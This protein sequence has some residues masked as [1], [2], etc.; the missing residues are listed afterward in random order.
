MKTS[1]LALTFTLAVLLGALAPAGVRATTLTVGSLD[2]D[3]STSTLRYLLNSANDG[4]VIQVPAGTIVLVAPAAI[5]SDGGNPDLDIQKNVTIQGAGAGQTVIDCGALPIMGFDVDPNNDGVHGVLEGITVQNCLFGIFLEGS[6]SLDLLDSSVV[7]NSGA[8]IFSTGTSNNLVIDG[9]DISHNIGSTG[10]GL[11]MTGANANVIITNST[12]SH[13]ES[14]SI[15]GGITMFSGSLSVFDSHI[16]DNVAAGPG[17]GIGNAGSVSVVLG[18]TEVSRNISQSTGGG[19]IFSAFTLDVENCDISDN[20]ALSDGD[21]GAIQS[22]FG[23]HVAGSLISGNRAEGLGGAIFSSLG[24]DLEDSTVSDNISDVDGDAAPT[25][26]G[27]GLFLA[28]ISHSIR[29]SVISGNTANTGLGGGIA[30]SAPSLLIFGS[31]LINNTAVQGDG[32]ALVNL[33]AIAVPIGNTTIAGNRAK[34]TSLLFPGKDSAGGGIVNMPGLNMNLVN[35]TLSGNEADGD[36]GGIANQGNVA[37]TNATVAGNV[38]DANAAGLSGGDGGGLWNNPAVPTSSFALRNSIVAGNQDDSAGHEAPDCLSDFTVSG[39]HFTVT[40]PNLVQNDGGCEILGDTGSVLSDDP[41][42]DTAGLADNEGPVVGNPDGGAVLQTIALQSGSPAIDGGS[43]AGCASTDERGI[44]RP[45]DGNGDGE[46]RCDLGAFEALEGSGGTTGGDTTGGDTTG[47]GTT[48]GTGGDGG[49]CALTAGTSSTTSFGLGLIA[50]IGLGFLASFRKKSSKA[51]GLFAAVLAVFG[52]SNAMADCTTPVTHPVTNLAVDDGSPGTLRFLIGSP[53]VQD[54]DTIEVPA[55]IVQFDA[56]SGSPLLVDKKITIRGAGAGTTFIDANFPVTGFPAIVVDSSGTGSALTLEGITVR[57]GSN[58]VLVTGLGSLEVI[59]SEITGNAGAGLLVTGGDFNNLI[60]DGSTVSNNG[61][62]APAGGGIVLGFPAPSA[63][64]AIITDSTITKNKNNDV[65][66]AGGGGIIILGGDV[67]IFN[68]HITENDAAG[69]GGGILNI[70]GVLNITGSEISDNISR[71]GNGQGGGGI[72]ALFETNIENC[73]ISGNVT[74]N[75]TGGGGVGAIGDVN[76][77]DSLIDG[78]RADGGGGGVTAAAGLNV[79][80]ST[81]SNN[82]ANND[83]AG[84]PAVGGG[85]FLVLSGTISE[86]VISGNVIKSGVGGGIADG[87]GGFGGLLTITDSVIDGNTAVDGDGGGLLSDVLPATIRNTTISNNKAQGGSILNG[88]D[89]ALG[90][91]IASGTN[92]GALQIINSTIAGNSADGDGGGIVSVGIL[93]LSHVTITGNTADANSGGLTNGDGGG[94]NNFGALSLNNTLIAGNVDGSPGHEA[95]DCSNAGPPST[96]VNVL[97]NNFIGDLDGCVITG[98]EG[99]ILSGDASLDPAG[100]AD[101]DGPSA[102][103]SANAVVLKTVALQA[104]SPAIDAATDGSCPSEDERGVERP[105]GEHCDLGAFEGEA[106]GGTTTGGDTTGGDTTGGATTGGDGGSG[107]C[108]LGEGTGASASGFLI[109]LLAGLALIGFKRTSGRATKRALAVL[110]GVLS[111]GLAPAVHAA[112][113]TVDCTEDLADA[114]P[115]DGTCDTG[116]ACGAGH[117]TGQCTLRAAVDEANALAGADDITLPAA[118]YQLKL[119]NTPASVPPYVTSTDE[120]ANAD[121]DLDIND[122]L[123]INGDGAGATIIDGNGVAL[124]DRVF[125]IDPANNGIGVSINGVTIQ[126]GRLSDSGAGIY[127]ESS[128]GASL[129]LTD[130]AVTANEAV[131]NSGAGIYADEQT[132]LVLERTTVSNNIAGSE[133]GGI[134]FYYAAGTLVDSIVSGNE[135]N[136]TAGGLYVYYGTLTVSGGSINHNTSGSNGGGLYNYYS[137]LVMRDCEVDSNTADGDG[138]GLYNEYTATIDNCRIT[139]NRAISDNDG[140]GIYNY[141]SMDLRNSTVSGNRSEDDGGGIYNYYTLNADNVTVDDNIADVDA[142]NSCSGGFG[143]NGG[144]GIYNY[145]FLSLANSKV[146]N[147]V[148]ATCHGGGIFDYYYMII[149]G[150]TIESNSTSNNDGGGIFVYG[151]PSIIRNSTIANNRALGDQDGGGDDSNGGGV[152]TGYPVDIS[153]S[154]IAGNTAVGDG[155]G[156]YVYDDTTIVNLNNVTIAFNKADADEDGSGDG[157]GLNVS[158]GNVSGAYVTLTNSI[159]AGNQDGGLGG[160]APDCFARFTGTDN[161]LTAGGPNVIGDATGCEIT[162][163][164]ALVKQNVDPLFD[165]AGLADNGGA[166]QTIALQAGSPALDAGDDGSCL[167]SDQRGIARPQDG[168]G[169]GTAHCDLGAVEIEAGGAAT[170]GTTG[171]ETTGGTTGATTGGTTGGADSS[172]GCALAADSSASGTSWLI[173]ALGTAL[174]IGLVRA[175]RNSKMNPVKTAKSLAAFT[176]AALAALLTSGTA[177]A[178]AFSVDPCSC[179]PTPGSCG[180]AINDGDPG[181]LRFYVNN[182]ALSDGDVITIPEACTVLLTSTTGDTDGDEDLDIRK[183]ITIQG[184]GA[185]SS[186]ID[187]NG[188]VTTARALEID[189][190]DEGIGVTITGLTIQNGQVAGNGGGILLSNHGQL[191]L[192]NSTVKDNTV[193][194]ASSYGG[195]IALYDQ[196]TSLNIQNTIVTGNK[197]TGV[198]GYGGGIAQYYGSMVMSATELSANETTGVGGGLYADDGGTEI[199][200]STITN[201]TADSDSDGDCGGG[202]YIAYSATTILNSTITKNKSL[203]GCGGGLYTDYTL[204]I[205]NSLL[206]ENEAGSDGGAVYNSDLLRIVNSTI[207]SNKAV[208]DGGGIFTDESAIIENSTISKNTADSDNDGTGDGGGILNGYQLIVRGSV[209]DTNNTMGGIGGGIYNNSSAYPTIENSVISNNS[210]DNSDAGGIYNTGY[211]MVIDKTTISGNKAQNGDGGGILNEYPL[212]MTNSTLSGNSAT[213]DGG[214][215]YCSGYPQTLNNVTVANNTAGGN[216]GGIRNL[217]IVTLTNSIIADNT[218]TGTGPDCQSDFSGSAETLISAGKNL[219]EEDDAD[220]EITGD[221]ASVIH[222]DPGLDTAGLADN[223]GLTAGD[224]D[225][226]VTIQTIALADGSAALDAGDADTCEKD[227]ERGIERPQGDGC[228][229]GAFELEVAGGTTTG[230]TGGTTGDGTGGT[231]AGTTGGTSDSGGCSLIR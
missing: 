122:D 226:P 45:V 37:L 231:T 143:S 24:T 138:G 209:I 185:D 193:T 110:V 225:S 89:D 221:K 182:L 59:D 1:R 220:C 172:G 32:G 76:I 132:A 142:D 162:G 83:D 52:A 115:G 17:G 151:E 69:N 104:G 80:N 35:V 184:A 99:R 86:S 90:G 147:N 20:Q 63:V 141:Y 107:G 73:V 27:G 108:S 160:N 81:I 2:D 33:A 212:I 13:N 190:D 8:G 34:G 120:D 36:G 125:H 113:F 64:S 116:I 214:G 72:A 204:L 29:N 161:A 167:P 136:S 199:I 168:D 92:A 71:G 146:T 54:C 195:G 211:A 26:A 156:L 187:A 106:A 85:I 139:G 228:D 148:T 103:N 155:G 31:S 137:S 40:G 192:L 77:I 61:A 62:V 67:Q 97:S 11:F 174:G 129:S 16:T 57:N 149:D 22:S 140:G 9:S 191:T 205:D 163:Q 70:L 98:N 10:G 131:G 39:N 124:D 224:P 222:G 101:N 135:S 203:D 43:D 169:D 200:S 217:Y 207:D 3:G 179:T 213:G 134:Y 56:G 44:D 206:S 119:P 91:G 94:V 111:L 197:I 68:S 219:I 215:L 28:G 128:S 23:M 198:G 127:L 157:G 105:Q 121:G 150:S 58:G 201:N 51:A 112:T 194:S 7:A 227:D 15:G 30:N 202:L 60:V 208:G 196:G 218:A 95:P 177:S 173:L 93:S 47:G 171:G 49:G 53:S 48:G 144:G 165:P 178:T 181:S 126:G 114:T 133:G 96:V 166:T 223:S 46:A 74:L 18:N 41:Q 5:D 180:A 189:T 117:G 6:G 158:E 186:I 229:L 102:G 14:P 152:W 50:L 84:P 175:R 130:S 176:L 153:N 42:F 38:A 78:N 25:I 75:D 123:T 109:A 154:T 118:T 79:F 82:I 21:G 19:A 4:D 216:G 66:P 210:A 145:Y 170:G 164:T 88:G 188:A 159:I 65:S 87:P 100:L 183:S 12:I 55:G 230:D